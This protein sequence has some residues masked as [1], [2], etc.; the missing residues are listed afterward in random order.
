V[1]PRAVILRAD[2]QRP[3]KRPPHTLGRTEAAG[4]GD[5]LHKDVR[6]L[7]LAARGLDAGSLDE[8]ATCRA[9]LGQKEPGKVARAKIFAIWSAFCRIPDLELFQKCF[10]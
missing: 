1:E 6:L 8:F 2:M 9:G 7:E 5:G 4:R 10:T 3:L